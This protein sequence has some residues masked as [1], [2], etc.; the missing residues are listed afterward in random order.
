MI[1]ETRKTAQGTEYW[2]TELKKSLFVPAGK[3]PAFEITVD[4][5]SMI[6]GVDLASGKDMTVIDDKNNGTHLEDM[7]VPQLK[8][9]AKEID[10]EIPSDIKKKDDIIEYLVDSK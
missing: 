9:F 8:K 4:P 5:P 3:K 1:V 6:G 7:S 10:V 2:D